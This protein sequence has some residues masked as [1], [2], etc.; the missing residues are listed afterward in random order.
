MQGFAVRRLQ[1]MT[2]TVLIGRW[3]TVK[4]SWDLGTR[5]MIRVVVA[6]SRVL[7]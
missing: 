7:L 6:P 3:H 1:D 4:G 5:V 2:G